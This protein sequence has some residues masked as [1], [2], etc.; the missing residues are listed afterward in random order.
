MHRGVYP[1]GVTGAVQYG[2]GVR[3]LVTKL[4]VEHRMPLEQISLLFEDLYGY[5]WNSETV[6]RALA[7]GYVLAEGVELEVREQLLGSAVVHFDETG[8]RVGGGLCRAE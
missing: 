6:E 8:L 3:A 2:G 1:A 4:S 7:Q 5:G